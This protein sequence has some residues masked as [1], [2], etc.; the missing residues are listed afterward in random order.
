MVFSCVGDFKGT[1]IRWRISRVREYAGGFEWYLVALAISRVL[2]YVG[3]FQ[4]YE[5]TLVDLNGI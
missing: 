3:G 5:N 2:G 1:W 4:G